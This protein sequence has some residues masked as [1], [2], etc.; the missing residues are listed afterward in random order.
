MIFLN[1][2]YGCYQDSTSKDVLH[3]SIIY[4]RISNLNREFHGFPF[5]ATEFTLV[6]NSDDKY[7]LFCSDYDS[8]ILK[9]ANGKIL[10]K[11]SFDYPKLIDPHQT[12]TMYLTFSLPHSKTLIDNSLYLSSSI[13][14]VGDKTCNRDSL[15]AYEYERI[16]ESDFKLIDEILIVQ[17]GSTKLMIGDN[18]YNE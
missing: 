14:Y 10:G 6:N 7:V 16:K 13:F 5:L 9:S 3:G 2:N 15:V 4:L 1:F 12:D 18:L 17:D 11:S 8:F